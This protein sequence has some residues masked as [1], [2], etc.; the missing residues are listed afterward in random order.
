M[1]KAFFSGNRARSQK[2]NLSVTVPEDIAI[3]DVDTIRWNKNLYIHPPLHHSPKSFNTFCQLGLAASASH[4][5]ASFDFGA[6]AV[7]AGA[8]PPSE[9]IERGT[10]ASCGGAT[11]LASANSPPTC[12]SSRAIATV[13]LSRTLPPDRMTN[14]HNQA[15]RCKS[16]IE[17]CSPARDRGIAMSLTQ[18]HLT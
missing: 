7:D 6:V 10:G 13:P 4:N 8:G 2:C 16:T 5:T 18:L 11:S 14:S 1:A 3:T 12:S 9:P 17:I 15:A